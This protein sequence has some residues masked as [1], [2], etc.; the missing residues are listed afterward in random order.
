MAR[1]IYSSIFLT[2]SCIFF[3]HL[4]PPGGASLAEFIEFDYTVLR[5]DTLY[6]YG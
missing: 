4:N 5:V 3:P 2:H 6:S 1:R